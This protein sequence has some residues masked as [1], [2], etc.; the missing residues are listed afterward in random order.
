[1]PAAQ[2][3][4]GAAMSAFLDDPAFSRGLFYPRPDRRGIPPGA[5]ELGIEVP[6]AVLHARLHAPDPR[7]RAVVV[8]FHGN[9]EIVGDYDGQAAAF[10]R[11][12][13]RLAVIDFRGYGR[14]TGEPSLR[15]LLADALPA[16]EAV[17]SH[18]SG[19]LVVMGRSL[20]SA[21]AA[22]V[23]GSA[24]ALA[25]GYV[26]E[27]G[28]SD[29]VAFARRRG[30]T[31]EAAAEEDT[32]ALCPKRKLAR[33]TAPLLLLHGEEDELIDPAEARA[34]HAASA[35]LDKR[36]VVIP[37]RGH[38]DLSLHPSYWEALAD[39]VTRVAA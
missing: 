30:V 5:R 9:G 38:N 1:M 8:L 20:G 31:L 15:T 14:S 21:C 12:G 24:P 6:G 33:S 3:A 25:A 28:F 37:R 4:Q 13:A 34:S 26:I 10:T 16:V 11:A 35:S 36:L 32:A 18:V 23:C 39:F 17:R 27:S 7:Q 22:Q 2:P 29:L 19:P